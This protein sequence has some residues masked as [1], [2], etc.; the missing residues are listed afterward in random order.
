ML[1][2]IA[3]V[4]IFASFITVFF[5]SD[6]NAQAE[7]RLGG[8][9]QS[10]LIFNQHQELPGDDLE[11]WGFRIRRARLTAQTNITDV[12]DVATWIEF[13]GSQPHLLDFMVHARFS[14]EFNVRIGQYRPPTQMYDTGILS[15]SQ[16]LFYERPV[17]SSRLSGIMGHDAFRD[18]G[19]MAMGRSGPIWYGFHVGNGMGRFHQAGTTVSSRDFGGGLFGGRVDISPIDGLTFGG[20]FSINNQSDVVRDGSQP[21]DIDRR[22]YSIRFATNNL[23]IPGLFSQFELGGGSADDTSVF[24]FS[25]YYFQAGFRISPEWTVL[26]RYD[27][28]KEDPAVGATIEEDN[29]TLG[30]L[31]FWNKDGREIIRIGTNYSFGE[32]DPG[33]F[34]RNILL[35]WFQ[36]RFLP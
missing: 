22:S 23:G 19:I 6:A 17:I 27:Y 8:Y 9:F 3:Q 2:K 14:P 11:N 35:L 36:I 7:L 5:A 24:D 10:W 30:A 26:A 29:I 1:K 4:F 25:G 31:Y 33:G 12:F 13:A 15:S 32:R 28:Y 20:H 21:Y 18:I 34:G 16:L